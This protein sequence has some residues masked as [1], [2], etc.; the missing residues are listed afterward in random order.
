[1]I[2]PLAHLQTLSR[3]KLLVRAAR[4]GLCEYNR[5]RSLRRILPG[6]TPPPRGR[7]SMPSSNGKM[8]WIRHGVTA[9][10]LI[11]PRATSRF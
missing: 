7:L 2:D 4:I 6:Q 10:P 11:R 3:P 1:M 5:E 9:G 8:H